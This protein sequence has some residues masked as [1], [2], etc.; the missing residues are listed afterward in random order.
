MSIKLIKLKM[1]NAEKKTEDNL[2]KVC[3]K[4]EITY[5]VMPCRHA[6]LCKKCS[7]KMASGG[8]CKVCHEF[9]VECKRIMPGEEKDEPKKE[10]NDEEDGK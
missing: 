4:N 1:E 8:K 5:R 6:Y 2:C 7:M 10:E 3:H 9:F